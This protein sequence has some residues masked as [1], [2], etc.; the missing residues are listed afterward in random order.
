VFVGSALLLAV[1]A[2]ALLPRTVWGREK[3]RAAV[4]SALSAQFAGRVRIGTI[5]GPLWSRATV[6]DVVISDSSGAPFIN[7]PL[8]T[9]TWTFGDLWNKR[10][11]LDNVRAERPVI[12]LD[13]LPGKRWNWDA[14]L[15]PDTTARPRSSAA[16]FGDWVEL[17]NV[18]LIDATLTSRSPYIVEPWRSVAARDSLLALA[19]AGKLRAVVRE[20]P[21]GYQRVTVLEHVTLTAPYARIK[22]PEQRIQ[23]FDI[24]HGSAI[25]RAFH[26]PALD[27]RDVAGRVYVNADSVWFRDVTAVL[28]N[29]RAALSGS[30]NLLSGDASVVA[31][32]PSLVTD[33]WLW[34]A[35]MLPKGGTGRIGDVR[36]ALRGASSDITLRGLELALERAR[37]SGTIDF[38]FDKDDTRFNDV[39]VRL[40]ALDTRLVH[41]L[42]PDVTPPRQG[43]LTGTLVARGPLT[44]A[45]VDG[46]FQFADAKA[47]PLSVRIRGVAGSMGSAV[48]ARNLRLDI[49]PLPV[50]LASPA[51]AELGGRVGGVVTVNG[52]T[53]GWLSSTL[54]LVHTVDGRKSFINGLARVNITG[55]EPSVDAALRFSPLSLASFG[56][57]APDLDLRGSASG[58][59]TLRGMLSSM[60]IDTRAQVESAGGVRV[61]GRFGVP[62]RGAAFADVV[63][64]ADSLDVQR[65]IPSA[66]ATRLVG[67]ATVRASGNS[68]ATLQGRVVVNLR[69]SSVDK[70][71]I[72][73]LTMLADARDGLLHLD[74]LMVR[75]GGA[76]GTGSGTFG[77]RENRRG[78]LNLLITIDSLQQLREYLPGDSALISP[79]PAA[80]A[81]SLRRQRADSLALARRTEVERAALGLAPI[82]LKITPPSS[83]RGDSLAGRAALKL[84]LHGWLRDISGTGALD[85]SALFVNGTTV[86]QIALLPTWQHILTDS[87]SAQLRGA[88]R[89]ITVSGYA[90]DSLRVVSGYEWRR[91][92][93]S[94]GRG[95]LAL[96]LHLIDSSRV[97]M[98]GALLIDSTQYLARVDSTRLVLP[99]SRWANTR[100]WRALWSQGRFVIDSLSLETEGDSRLQ[101]D[102]AVDTAGT[103][104]VTMAIRNTQLR[105]LADLAQTVSPL[106]GRVS[107]DL[108]VDGLASD[109]KISFLAAVRDVMYDS[110]ALPEIR[111]RMNYKAQ[112]A[113]GYAE[114]RRP[115]QQPNARADATIPVNL[116][117]SGVTGSRMLEQPIAADIRLDSLPLDILPALNTSVTGVKGETVGRVKVTGTLPDRLS[118]DGDLRL[119]KGEAFVVANEVALRE[120]AGDVH[121]RGDSMIVDSVRAQSGDG[122]V[123]ITGG[124]GLKKATNPVFDLKLVARNARVLDGARG[125][126]RGLADLTLTGP[127]TGA[128]IAGSLRVRDGVYH[129]QEP[130]RAT[131]VLNANDPAV[132]GAVDST[133]ALQL[134]L[135]VPVSDFVRGLTTEVVA[136][137]DRNVWVRSADANVE[138]FTDGELKVA[139]NSLTGGVTLDGI[140]ATERGQYQ[141]FQNRFNI[142]RGSATF[143]GSSDL[144]PL[145]Q[146]VAEV[147]IRQ[148]AQSELAIRLN[149]GGTLVR[150]RLSLESDAQPPIPQTELISYLAFG[151][152]SGSLLTQG[153]AGASGVSSS[154]VLSGTTK[155]LL[156]NQLLP[157][158]LGTILNQAGGN[159][160]RTLGADV[161]TI[162][163][164]NVASELLNSNL[165]G[166]TRFLFGSEIEY[167]RYFGTQS[168]LV[169]KLV[170][171]GLA[172][173]G[174]TAEEGAAF[175][176]GLRWEYR[177]AKGYRF[178]TSFGPRFLLQGQTLQTRAPNALKNFGLFLSREWKW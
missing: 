160:G 25:V 151:T 58:T 32:S 43:I 82:A 21:G 142:V 54:A 71:R 51:L 104:N 136:R 126:I 14:I 40:R 33:D 132:L 146:A 112:Q 91:N 115:G 4:E 140:V 169:L 66:I 72:D 60:A 99:A 85:A 23:Q 47:G 95:D 156:N 119:R 134:G 102:A 59:V 16:Q 143:I 55:A 45:T 7:A 67:T 89:G 141:F 171:S 70:V 157:M 64:L 120:M 107:A 15:F 124:V 105:D 2:A 37:L 170:P 96:D 52:R 88:A 30:Y 173:L 19:V 172:S 162:T 20:V 159:L 3:I 8:I 34:L 10:V 5:D 111:A 145:L 117:L 61:T 26:P 9:A 122:F 127:Y 149:I 22:Y 178:E 39:N 50:T 110:L 65:I 103:T 24:A 155:A 167:G 75:V 176:L 147:R 158:A 150:P 123:R 81:R 31:S 94:S 90:M 48:A 56:R 118:F 36:Y 161:L 174:G 92:T 165:A 49:A 135:V 74:T 53:D 128:T 97:A 152:S 17:R 83:I 35:P 137:V 87:S 175:P 101:V 57:Y 76:V 80:I 108:Y 139:V 114:V 28:P 93:L 41:R 177:L 86:E 153:G 131:Q 27:L 166:A 138:I 109:P 6:H 106:D 18:Q 133:E 154:G 163:P 77:L 84:T 125:R 11:I 164:T 116:A 168:Y 68:A 121:F 144:N 78:D 63:V 129:L 1:A 38:G 29:S 113:V 12:V 46:S 130:A 98:N 62:E 44:G 100:P 148:A 13:R 73:T 79:T 42:L 69:G